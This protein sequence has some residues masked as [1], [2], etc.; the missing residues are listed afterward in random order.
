MTALCS[1]MRTP[2]AAAPA[3]RPP[4][5]S[6]AGSATSAPTS[7]ET[8][9][10]SSPGGILQA[11]PPPCAYWVSR[12]AVAVMS[13]RVTTPLLFRVLDADC[14]YRARLYRVLHPERGLGQRVG[15]RA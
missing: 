15:G 4:I 7:P 2:A 11:Q 3:S 13:A 12:I 1:A 14:C 5:S 9:D 8:T 10:S 6:P